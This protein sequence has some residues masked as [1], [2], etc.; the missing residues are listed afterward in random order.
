MLYALAIFFLPF[1]FLFVCFLFLFSLF[2]CHDF[3]FVYNI[4][5]CVLVFLLL[6]VCFVSFFADLFVCLSL[7]VCAFF[8]YGV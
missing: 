8:F 7:Y 5:H 2:E 3:V 6:F 4:Q 1:L